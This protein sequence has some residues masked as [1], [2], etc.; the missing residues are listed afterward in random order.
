MRRLSL[1]G[2]CLGL[3]LSAACRVEDR[4]P[5]GSRR[6]EDAVQA[7]VSEYAR[8]LSDRRWDEVRA[9]FWREGTYSGP[10]V[11]GSLGHA[12]P[13][14]SALHSMTARVGQLDPYSFDV[15]VL[16]SD[17]RQDGDLAAVWVTT[18]RRLPLAGGA[19][20]SERDW[21]EH[22]V[23]RRIGEEWRILSVA[24]AAAPR[25]LLRDAR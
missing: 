19:G 18:R 15:R 17:F 21:M 5:S 8:D 20:V 9:L 4:T 6:D 2:I 3:S 11:P 24:G 14:D 10:M 13:I 22:L 23:F 1:A 12:V 16:R 25:R 7:L